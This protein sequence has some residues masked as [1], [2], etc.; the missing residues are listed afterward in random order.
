MFPNKKWQDPDIKRFEFGRMGDKKIEFLL[1][2]ALVAIIV[3][4]LFL[5][6]RKVIWRGGGRTTPASVHLIC[7]ACDHVFEISSEE[8]MKATEDGGRYGGPSGMM[9]MMSGMSGPFAD[10]P[11]P[12]CGE[13]LSAW[14]AMRCCKP[15]CEKYYVSDVLVAAYEARQAGRPYPGDFRNVCPYCGTDQ[16]DWHRQRAE[17]RRR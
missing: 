15:D 17:E 4:S 1:A 16:A 11:N 14:V 9:A 3:V 6:L 2:G 7:L 12:E 10:C 8:A 13:K 5:S